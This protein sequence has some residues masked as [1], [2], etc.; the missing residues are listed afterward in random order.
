MPTTTLPNKIIA[1][2]LSFAL[3][4]SFTPSIAFADQDTGQQT[5]NES[6][7]TGNQSQENS[8]SSSQPNNQS[9][10]ESN[11]SSSG[12]VS[13][14]GTLSSSGPDPV[15]DGVASSNDDASQSTTQ[16]LE[17]DA[18][19]EFIYID[20]KEVPLNETQSIVVSFANPENA[21]SAILWFQKT[22][23]GLQSVK[24]S[25]IE[26]GAALFELTFTSNEQIGN[27]NL[28]KVSWEGST[29]GEAVISSNTDTGYLFSVIEE[30]EEENEEGITAYSIDDSGNITE[31]ESVADA[32]E[33]SAKADNGIAPLS[34]SSGS[35]ASA[36]SGSGG[37]VIALDPGHGG[38]DPGAVNGS[39]VE[40]T[41]N[42]KIAQYCRAAL[43][44]YSGIT[45]FMTRTGDEYV[46]LTERVTRAVNAGAD[47]FVS[48]H[49]NSATSTA[50]GF[51]VWVQNDSSWR[52]YLH[53]ESSEL[54]TAILEK[55]KKFGITNRGNK[56]SDYGNGV[57]YEDGSQADGLAVLRESRKNNIPAVL[58][59]HGFINGS[60][61]DQALLS[62][63]SSLKAMGEA[64]AEAIAEY[65]DLSVDPKPNVKIKS[66]DNGRVTLAWDPVDGA[67][68]YAIA[69]YKG[70]NTY[71]TYT[72][73]CTNTEYTI[74][75]LENGKTYE[76][77]VQAYL[78]DHWS[79]YST[80]DHIECTVIPQPKPTVSSV[81]DGTVTLSWDPIPGATK[82]AISSQNPGVNYSLDCT[83][84]TYT[85][86]NLANGREYNFLVQAYV[87][88]KWS[89]YSEFNYVKA[90]PEG[91]VKPSPT[92]TSVGNGTVTLSWDAVSGATKYA[93]S[94]QNPGVNYELN[95]TGTTYTVTGLTNG[96][97]YQ[98]LVQAY[99]DGKWSSYTEEDMV[100]AKLPGYSIMGTSNA[101][102]GQMVRYF[103]ASG[104]VYPE[105]VYSSK[106]ASTINE[107]CSAIYEQANAE[108]VRAEVLFS[109][110]MWETGW[111]QFGGDVK[112]EQ[113]NFG[114]LGATGN[115]A[116]GNSFP[117]VQIG[118]RAQAQHL[119]AYASFEPV[120]GP[121]Y[122]TRFNY[123]TRGT[124]PCVEDLGNG[125]WASDPNYGL[126]LS[127]LINQLLSY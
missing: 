82:Y 78:S 3:I 46:G 70:N 110:V 12:S 86:S 13:S 113:C 47:V 32:I 59:E 16:T 30:T 93:I 85:I 88:G 102:I 126:S 25:Q 100:K 89:S 56:E 10:R 17:D 101:S 51:E 1:V 64:D 96:K 27:Y 121:L 106:G 80:R 44:Q 73:D 83:D 33:E 57:T 9:S 43:D 79:S 55:L 36:R 20:Q 6:T 2:L 119:K 7:N 34:L 11:E 77:L 37:M 98:F 103:S 123:V 127:R 26:D 111:L 60:A 94:S 87:N 114:G 31:E 71:E 95:C 92:V 61:A 66:I 24:P 120:N 49:I 45:T 107:F 115:G 4:F 23:G 35:N 50:T 122:D 40:K 58:I 8:S 65:Y 22:D 69:C 104:N 81:G 109:Q 112:P 52:Y 14:E 72:L 28:V 84:T 75:G 41:L 124:A 99:V 117:S 38:S 67:S 74:T 39:L 29:P 54:G 97:E 108:G 5:T 76:F 125:K 21:N 62:S 53:Q 63:E 15:E 105:S 118:L 91:P 116:Q 18:A 90:T 19:F 42:L 48:F 68:K